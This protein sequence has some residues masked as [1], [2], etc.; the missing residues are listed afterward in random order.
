MTATSSSTGI[1]LN[2][3]PVE[4]A[5]LKDGDLLTIDDRATLRFATVPE[6]G[7]A[8][9]PFLRIVRDSARAAGRLEAGPVRRGLFFVRD[10]CHCT[11]CDA[12]RRVKVVCLVTCGV[13]VAGSVL[14]GTAL[15]RV[16]AEANREVVALSEQVAAGT[17]SRHRLEQQVMQLRQREQES[18]RSEV[19]LGQVSEDLKTAQD[20]L[21]RLER[22]PPELSAAIDNARQSVGFLLVGYSLYEKASGKPLRFAS[23]D[24]TAARHQDGY[25]ASVDGSGPVVTS[26]AIGSGFLIAGGQIVTNRHVAQP[27][28]KDASVDAAI[29]KGFE[30]RHTVLRA[31]FTDWSRPIELRITRVSPE[32][33]IALL[34]G[35]IPP[36][37][38][39]LTL[40]P[41]ERRV[42]VG[43]PIVVVGYPTGLDALLAKTDEAVAQQIVDTARDDW[44]ALAQTLAE[45]RLI[46]PLVTMGHVGDIAVNK[47]VHDAATTY[48]SSGGPVLTL[49]G[50]VIALNYAGLE[51]FTGARFGIPIAL[52]HQ[53]P[54]ALR[55]RAQ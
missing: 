26:Y 21:S 51:Q 29:A 8:G 3:Q 9:K 22:Q 6:P 40:A 44:T 52:V 2:G 37:R 33:D 30:P 5:V 24:A 7:E 16:N 45:K 13:V 17:V 28:W 53:L 55:N 54:R 47:I 4:A 18:A 49:A 31:Y 46:T 27:W 10:L 1:T 48:G 34:A 38:S 14:L 23:A 25:E 19:R 50:E 15:L 32:A 20:R 11:S 42:N 41:P 43:D 35:V 39:P 12:S 36:A